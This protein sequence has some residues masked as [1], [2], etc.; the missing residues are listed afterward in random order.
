MRAPLADGVPLERVATAEQTP[1]YGQIRREGRRSMV[2]VRVLGDEQAL[3]GELQRIKAGV[4]LPTGYRV[5]MGERFRNRRQNEEGGQFAVLMAVAMVFFL[6]GVLFESFILPF[7]ILLTIPLAFCGVFWTLFLTDTALDIMAIIGCIILVG[8]V[9]NNG[10]VLID[11]VQQRRTDGETRTEALVNAGRDRV[12][13]ILMTAMTT[14]GGLIPMAVGKASMLGIEYAPLGRVVI[15]G[16]LT[17]TVL[18][19]FAVPLFYALLD[20]LR[21]LPRR[22]RLVVRRGAAEAAPAEG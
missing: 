16:L 7:S 21:H 13:P 9:V 2:T 20:D 3:F 15:G 18:T 17:G 14:I 1:G 12:R 10:I 8:V 19:L 6:M 22:A 11:Q 5:E 4:E